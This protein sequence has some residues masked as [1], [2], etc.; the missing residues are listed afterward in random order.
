M[1]VEKYNDVFDRIH[2]YGI[3]VLGALIY[4]L[5]SDDIQDLFDRTKFAIDSSMDAMQATIVTP[6]PGT[7]LFNRMKKEGRL[8]YTNYPEDWQYY[9][10]LEVVHHPGKMEPDEF[11]QAMLDNWSIM[12]DDKLLQ[13]KMLRSLKA[14]KSAKAATWAYLSNVERHN[15]CFGER[16]APLDPNIL[17]KSLRNNE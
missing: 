3:S 4:G 17:L 8:L 15:I 9:H 2:K 12:Y 5:D 1:G 14:T 13:K 11:M 10:F 7:G 6:L 16:K